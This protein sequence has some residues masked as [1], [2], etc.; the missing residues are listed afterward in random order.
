MKIVELSPLLSYKYYIISL[1]LPLG[2]LWKKLLS[3][4]LTHHYYHHAQLK[5]FQPTNG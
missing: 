4:D 2:P 5:R 1:I 3:P